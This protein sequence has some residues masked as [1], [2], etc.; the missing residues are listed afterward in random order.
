MARYLV[1]NAEALNTD[2][3]IWLQRIWNSSRDGAW[4]GETWEENSKQMEDR[5]DITQNHYDHVHLSVRP[6]GPTGAC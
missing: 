5:G 1:E 4:K 2:C 6:R 3:V